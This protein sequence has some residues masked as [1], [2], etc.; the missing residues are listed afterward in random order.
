MKTTGQQIDESPIDRGRDEPWTTRLMQWRWWTVALRGLLAILFGILAIVLP[1]V[2]FMS[3]VIVF[4][5]FAI[6]DGV[7]T[8]SLARRPRSGAVVARGI[9]SIL[10]GVIALVWPG[11]TALALLLVIAAWA[12]VTGIFEIATAIRFRRVMRREWLLVVEGILAVAFGAILAVSPLVGAIAIGLWIG[13]Y[14]L[15]I[16]VL[17]VIAGFQLR[18]HQRDAGTGRLAPA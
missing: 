1:G 14:A 12:V 5:I 9:A 8:L 2:A 18:G 3:L 6:V 11:I 15:V 10:V 7:L 4:G 16:G 17:L 13:A